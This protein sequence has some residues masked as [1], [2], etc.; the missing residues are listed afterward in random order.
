ATGS[1]RHELGFG[2]LQ[3]R[4]RNRFQDQAYNYVGSGNVFGTAVTAADP[5]L[6]DVNTDRDERSTEF[7]VQDAIRWNDR[8]TTWLGVRH[9][10]LDRDSVRTDGSRP[11]GYKD[12]LTTPWIAASYAFAPGLNAYASWGKGV[13]SQIVPNKSSQY[14]NAGVALP[15]LDSRQWELGIK[16]GD[17]AL[18]WQLAYF[19]IDRPITNLDACNRL[20]TEACEGRFDG[21]AR[22]RGIEASGQW[23]SG[24]WRLAGGVTLIDA[25]REGSLIEPA[26]NGQ[27][28]TNVPR[29]VVR[30]QAAYRLASLPGLELQGR[31]SHEGRRNVLADGSVTLPAWTQFDAA[32][33]YDTVQRGVRLTWSAAIE[34]V[35]DRRYWK[36]SPYQFGH[37]Y[38]FPGA[39]RTLRLGL[40]ASL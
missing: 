21:R 17:A 11:T 23:T 36:E 12:G 14:T 7:S 3:S 9:T 39:P 29:Q 25:E 18:G 20:G 4:T 30:A 2:L 27:R 8:F 10:R 38:L 15:A 31:L 26:L 34:N 16:G 40:S 19:D 5:T 32:L 1:V 28:P 13:E 6:T 35:F 33:R 24:P 37:V 22:H